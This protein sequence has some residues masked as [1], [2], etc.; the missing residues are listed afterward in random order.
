MKTIYPVPFSA[1]RRRITKIPGRSVEEGERGNSCQIAMLSRRVGG[2]LLWELLAV[3]L[4]SSQIQAM[5]RDLCCVFFLLSA[6]KLVTTAWW[7]WVRLSCM[8]CVPGLLF[9]FPC[10]FFCGFPWFSWLAYSKAL[11]RVLKLRVGMIKL[12]DLMQWEHWDY[13]FLCIVEL[14]WSPSAV[15]YA[16]LW[17]S[18]PQKWKWES[19]G[20]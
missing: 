16:D 10:C 12:E 7:A 9:F 17:K 5:W 8:L 19:S 18:A 2:A 3:G 14:M 20:W 4:L 15:F 1:A 6:E 11:L 13:W